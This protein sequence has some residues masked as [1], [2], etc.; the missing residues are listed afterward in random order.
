VLHHFTYCASLAQMAKRAPSADLARGV[1]HG[2][3]VLHLGR[4]LN[5]PAARLPGRSVLEALPAEPER[6][7]ARLLEVC[8]EQSRVDEAAALVYRYLTLGH[9]LA[10]LLQAMARVT[11]REDAAFHDYQIVEEG[12]ALVHDLIASGHTEPARRV[13][14]GIARWQAAHSPT[15]RAVTQTYD[16]ARRLHRG[17]SVYE[18]PEEAAQEAAQ[19]AA[20]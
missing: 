16:I 4:F 19:G 14:V 9:D 18:G 20:P 8:D 7:T 6:L 10:P 11:L 13:L 1:L 12:F 5:I 15:R 2:A 3:M 17:E